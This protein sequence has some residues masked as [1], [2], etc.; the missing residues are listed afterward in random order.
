LFAKAGKYNVTLTVSDSKRQTASSNVIVDISTA[1][2]SS[3]GNTI[4]EPRTTTEQNTKNLNNTNDR[5]GGN[6]GG[7]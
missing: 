6:S 4:S 5:G 2:S 3:T 1:T 7:R